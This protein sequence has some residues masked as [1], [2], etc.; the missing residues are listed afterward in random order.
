[1]EYMVLKL[2]LPIGANR[3]LVTS[4]KRGN[5]D[6]IC[7]VLGCDTKNFRTTDSI[8]LIEYTFKNFEYIYISDLI[9]KEFD[10]WKKEHLN[11][12]LVNKGESNNLEIDYTKID[13]AVIPILKA[14]NS[15]IE[16]NIAIQQEFE[17]PI[18]QNTKIGV[19]TVVSPDGV[20]AETDVLATNEIQKKNVFSYLKDLFKQYSSTLNSVPTLF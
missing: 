7:V 6:I 19:I 3:C 9:S 1:M 11:D 8:K 17:A 10:N 14:Y 5:M 4:C 2:V 13:T 15:S 20:I 12:F 16:V 18:L